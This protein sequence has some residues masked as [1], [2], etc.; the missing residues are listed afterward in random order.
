M[1]NTLALLIALASLIGCGPA[2]EDGDTCVTN[3]SA[4]AIV[5]VG[6]VPTAVTVTVCTKRAQGR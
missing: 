1:K 5:P 4:V 2:S 6:G 3:G